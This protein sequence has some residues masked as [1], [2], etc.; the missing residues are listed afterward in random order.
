MCSKDLN[1]TFERVQSDVEKFISSNERVQLFL[2]WFQLFRLMQIYFIW[3]SPFFVSLFF[4]CDRL[5]WISFVCLFLTFIR[6]NRLKSSIF[7]IW[8]RNCKFC[9]RGMMDLWFV[10]WSVVTFSFCGWNLS[11][12]RCTVL[13]RL[14]SVLEPT[15]TLTLAEKV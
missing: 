14:N 4:D 5:E 2:L 6:F 10:L 11:S 15:R 13:E 1:E 7:V 12:R 8:K 3:F 9:L